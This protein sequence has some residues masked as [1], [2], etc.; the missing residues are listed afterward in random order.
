MPRSARVP[1]TLDA[2]N[3]YGVCGHFNPTGIPIPATARI[4]I[5]KPSAPCRPLNRIRFKPSDKMANQKRKIEVFSAGCMGCEE[6]IAL[7]KRIACSSCEVTVHD[8]RKH[9]LAERAKYLRI[10]SVPAATAAGKLSGLSWR[11]GR[12]DHNL[13]S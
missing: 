11:L 3:S 6:T 5:S 13:R 10:H 4:R 2:D 9:D 7:V 1:A 8:M 12:A